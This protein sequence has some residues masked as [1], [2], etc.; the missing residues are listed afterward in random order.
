MTRLG[1]AQVQV[2]GQVVARARLDLR[3]VIRARSSRDYTLTSA[4]SER[5][6]YSR[7]DEDFDTTHKLEFRRSAAASA[8]RKRIDDDF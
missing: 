8:P 4:G 5:W 6:T 2:E 3:G 1:W 7:R